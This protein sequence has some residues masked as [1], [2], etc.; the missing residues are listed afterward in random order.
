MARRKTINFQ[1]V[2]FSFPAE[3]VK[4]LRSKVGKQSMSKFVVD[5]VEE[6]LID[7]ADSSADLFT[8]LDA[9]KNKLS[10]PANLKTKKSSLQLLREIRYGNR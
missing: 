6:R 9:L 8:R 3:V 4:K 5:A 1:R 7:M 10:D 2:T